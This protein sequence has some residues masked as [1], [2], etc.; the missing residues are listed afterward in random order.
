VS[1]SPF[2]ATVDMTGE[3]QAAL[4][5]LSRRTGKSRNALIRAAIDA[6]LA[7]L[8]SPAEAAR[9]DTVESCCPP[10]APPVSSRVASAGVESERPKKT[11][12][13][14]RWCTPRRVPGGRS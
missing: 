10:S 7:K 5:L 3:Q 13:S 9:V 4:G 14:T 11:R 8:V 2:R 12:A 6:Y 1:T